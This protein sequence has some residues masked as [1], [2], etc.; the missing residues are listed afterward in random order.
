V[1][2][3]PEWMR[4]G[5]RAF[6]ASLPV[7]QLVE[8]PGEALQPSVTAAAVADLFAGLPSADGPA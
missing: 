5:R 8:L 7:A 3:Q 6:A 4:A 1:L 2:R